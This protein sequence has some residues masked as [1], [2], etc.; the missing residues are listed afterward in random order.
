MRRWSVTSRRTR[1]GSRPGSA[2]PRCPQAICCRSTPWSAWSC[3][4]AGFHLEQIVT[5]DAERHATTAYAEG[6]RLG[7]RALAV[8]V[9]QSEDWDQPYDWKPPYRGKPVKLDRHEAT[10]GGSGRHRWIT[11][12]IRTSETFESFGGAP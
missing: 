2:P 6:D 5:S 4:P 7:D 9:T 3:H 11:W 8:L 10:M 1:P 12:P